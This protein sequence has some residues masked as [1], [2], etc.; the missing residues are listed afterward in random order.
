MARHPDLDISQLMHGNIHVSEGDMSIA[1]V[2]RVVTK[3]YVYDNVTDRII[4]DNCGNSASIEAVY[5]QY[6]ETLHN[7]EH[8]KEA[9]LRR[10]V[11]MTNT[12]LKEWGWD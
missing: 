8:Y 3:N 11:T 2:F 5:K 1:F 10:Y 4:L 12:K 9:T 7:F 6:D